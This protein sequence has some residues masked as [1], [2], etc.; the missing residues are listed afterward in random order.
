MTRRSVRLAAVA[1]LAALA[2]PLA[3][4]QTQAGTVAFVGEKRISDAQLEQQVD[5]FFAD[6]F[7]GKQVKQ[8]E[9]AEVRKRTIRAMVLREIFQQAK[10]NES[11]QVADADV[12]KIADEYKADPNKVPEAFRGAPSPLLAEIFA[13]VGALQ[14]KLSAAV[15]NPE[16][17]SAKF[18]AILKQAVKDSPV[19]MNP[20]YGTFSAEGYGIVPRKDAGVRDLP[21]SPPPLPTGQTPEGGQPEPQP[22]EPQPGEPQQQPQ[23]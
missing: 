15:A 8:T 11:V 21:V 23:N 20:R 6:P 14:A 12:K 19:E 1:V 18:D 10:K 4:C 7:W 13:V 16:E 2:L 22:G 9:R 3:G 17:A 5:A